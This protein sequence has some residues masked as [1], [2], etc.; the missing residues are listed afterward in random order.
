MCL[1]IVHKYQC[2]HDFYGV[3]EYTCGDH[4]RAVD[5]GLSP[6]QIRERGSINFINR[7]CPRCQPQSGLNGHRTDDYGSSGSDRNVRGAQGGGSYGSP[8]SF[9]SQSGGV[10]LAPQGSPA[11]LSTDESGGVPLGQAHQNSP[12]TR[13]DQSNPGDLSDSQSARSDRIN[14]RNNGMNGYGPRGANRRDADRFTGSGS[15]R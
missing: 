4:R 5:A 2:P 11:S 9:S 7:L 15:S 12:A 10:P 1:Y 3:K 14:Q 6:C 8:A 13:S